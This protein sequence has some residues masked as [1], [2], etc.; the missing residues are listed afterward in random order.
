MSRASRRSRPTSTRP[1]STPPA[2]APVTD[3]EHQA[4]A[5]D[6]RAVPEFDPTDLV[7]IPLD[8]D[9]AAPA[10]PPA[11][12]GDLSRDELER[13]MES[14]LAGVE[15]HRRLFGDPFVDDD[16]D[17]DDGWYDVW[18]DDLHEDWP[19]DEDTDA[20]ECSL[21]AA[22]HRRNAAPTSCPDTA[23]DTNAIDPS[24]IAATPTEADRRAV[25]AGLAHHVGRRLTERGYASGAAPLDITLPLD[26]AAPLT[27]EA[28]LHL[29]RLSMTVPAEHQTMVLLLDE[30]RCGGVA[31]VVSGTVNYDAVISVVLHLATTASVVGEVSS[32]VV[33]SIRPDSDG[34]TQLDDVD[35]WFCIDEITDY[36]GIHLIEWYVLDG[37][38]TVNRPRDLTF[39]P[40]R[41]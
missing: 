8:P 10:V 32:M 4:P 26:P 39:E 37:S 38:G 12:G 2:T 18:L 25:E 17:A 30:R 33:A 40:S 13:L 1:T 27:D 35:R 29:I 3:T 34:S 41:W 36:Q 31:V 21:C 22:L 15:P 11:A 28:A 20:D 23:F 19:D 16:E 6:R 9:P 24:T 5:G 14:V 7:D